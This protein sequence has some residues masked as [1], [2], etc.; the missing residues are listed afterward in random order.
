MELEEQEQPLLGS[1]KSLGS[2]LEYL[3]KMKEQVK[4]AQVP[5]MF[6]RQLESVKGNLF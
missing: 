2:I 5:Q 6:R 3:E 4:G 1:K